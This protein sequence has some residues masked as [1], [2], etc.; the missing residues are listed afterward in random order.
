MELSEVTLHSRTIELY[1][2]H[3]SLESTDLPFWRDLAARRGGP[4]LELGCGTGR[5]LL[6][7]AQQGYTLF[8]LDHDLGMLAFLKNHIPEDCTG[9]IHL[10]QA[11]MANFRLGRRFPLILMPCNTLS[12]LT[13]E[14][15]TRT[16]QRV[17]QH[18]SPGGIFAASLPNPAVLAD[19]PAV[20]EAEAEECL[21]EPQSG[22]AL[23]V[24]S[25]WEKTVN[26]FIL[27]WHYDTLGTDGSLER[28]TVESRH[29]L[30]TRGDYAQ[31][32]AVA[33]L[34]ILEEYGDFDGSPYDR[35]AANLI[36]VFG[37]PAG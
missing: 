21:V 24:S 11:D 35:D 1:H 29:D 33:G 31:A 20:G 34:E 18:L 4:L 15:R 6:P 17:Y 13:E 36:L 23:Q 27:R 3:H 16:L 26:E 5:V 28:R 37:K 12:T 14:V 8:G 22:Q 7:L 2:L 9:S 25:E 30:A 32:A 19:L 10:L